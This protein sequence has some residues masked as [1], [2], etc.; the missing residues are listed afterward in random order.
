[1]MFSLTS[2]KKQIFSIDKTGKPSAKLFE[3]QAHNI[4]FVNHYLIVLTFF[5]RHHIFSKTRMEQYA[6]KGWLV[7]ARIC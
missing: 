3:L 2:V 6:F 1:M 5:I 7:D 4:V